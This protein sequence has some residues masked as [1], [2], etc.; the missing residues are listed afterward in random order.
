M[1][2]NSLRQLLKAH[3]EFDPEVFHAQQQLISQPEKIRTVQPPSN[4]EFTQN[5]EQYRS[6]GES[7]V[8]AGKVACLM[9]AGG[10][11]TRLGF[12]GPKGCYPI[13]P[14]RH[15][16]LFGYFAE[17]LKAA[18]E[19]AGKN[20]PLA[21]MTSPANHAEVMSYF[22]THHYFGCSKDQISFFSQGS[23]P[24]LNDV[25]EIVLDQSGQ[26]AF[27]P[28]GNGSSIKSLVDSGIA[29]HWEKQGIEYVVFIFV[30]NPL[31]DP[32]DALL[33]G[34]HADA[35]VDVSIKAITR[36]DPQEKVGVI[37]TENGKTA[38]VEYTEMPKLSFAD[39][40]KFP[41]ANISLFCFSLPFIFKAA[42]SK[43]PLHKALKAINE[44]QKAW[45]FE[46]YIFD[47]LPL[48]QKTQTIIYPRLECFAPVKDA[49]N[50][51]TV[52]EMMTALDRKTF[53]RV[54]KT[55]LPVEC[56]EINPKFYYPTPELIKHWQGR[57][58]PST[59]YLDF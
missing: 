37:V 56:K 40:K 31:A 34:A 53:E 15:Q 50:V 5:L 3:P 6:L 51:P 21:I 46:R 17:R 45:K 24:F 41:I 19:Q 58:P 7:L 23:L 10:Q 26:I 57:I 13:T 4:W 20:L 35:K 9:V 59:P 16:T 18:S 1:N 55:S 54:A 33:V 38:V 29:T 36:D 12:K 44:K 48:A 47:I 52:Q 14:A 8:K 25:G 30:D 2:Q 11:G 32:F 49:D 42:K 43:L 27:G 22:Q 39:I 28:D